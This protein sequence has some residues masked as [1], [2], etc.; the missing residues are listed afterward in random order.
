MS[1]LLCLPARISPLLNK[2]QGGRLTH[3]A[4][5]TPYHSDRAFGGPV[6]QAAVCLVVA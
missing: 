5:V 2:Q 1:S 3:T 6:C 4:L